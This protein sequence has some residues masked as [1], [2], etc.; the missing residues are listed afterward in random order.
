MYLC[1]WHTKS[2]YMVLE[3]NYRL[4]HKLT[5]ILAVEHCRR[6]QNIDDI[7]CESLVSAFANWFNRDS[8]FW[9]TTIDSDGLL[10]MFTKFN[11]FVYKKK[12]L[13]CLVVQTYRKLGVQTVPY[14]QYLN[15]LPVLCKLLY[16]FL[17]VLVNLRV[18]NY[19]PALWTPQG[20]PALW[21]PIRGGTPSSRFWFVA[22]F[23]GEDHI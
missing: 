4:S 16:S 12:L 18:N 5:G 21:L 7:L 10:S 17:T 6:K 22:T 20:R 9:V 14:M 13:L 23:M 3:G 15:C 19:T 8:C 2:T 11:L 1:F